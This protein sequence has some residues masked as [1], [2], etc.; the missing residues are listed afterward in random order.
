MSDIKLRTKE[1]EA[2]S[3]RESAVRFASGARKGGL[4]PLKSQSGVN[5]CAGGLQARQGKVQVS[6]KALGPARRKT[7]R[8][9]L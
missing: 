4:K 1:I 5:F 7:R 8:S 9:V 3:A 2:M 6:V